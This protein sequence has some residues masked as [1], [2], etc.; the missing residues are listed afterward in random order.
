[1]GGGPKMRPSSPG[2]KLAS[3]DYGLFFVVGV[4]NETKRNETVREARLDFEKRQSGE[5]RVDEMR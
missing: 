4:R 3:W 2:L 5:W 1:M